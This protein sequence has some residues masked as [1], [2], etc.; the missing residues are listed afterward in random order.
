MISCS[1]TSA[2]IR[3]T[4]KTLGVRPWGRCSSRVF[5]PCPSGNHRICSAVRTPTP[6][7]GHRELG[8]RYAPPLCLGG[9]APLPRYRRNILCFCKWGYRGI[10]PLSGYGTESREKGLGFLNGK[11][12][13]VWAVFFLHI[14][15]PKGDVLYERKRTLAEIFANRTGGGLSALPQ[16][17]GKGIAESAPP[18]RGIVK[19]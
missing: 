5:N 17:G 2:T 9:T 6:P 18:Y 16:T 8:F 12:F 7:Q 4:Y 10:I 14:L 19:V 15:F 11:F 1:K 13:I 3:K